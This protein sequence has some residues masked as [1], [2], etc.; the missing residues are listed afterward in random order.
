MLYHGCTSKTAKWKLNTKGPIVC[1]SI[2]TEFPEYANSQRQE[3]DWWGL[4]NRGEWGVT[5]N[6]YRV[7]LRGMSIV[8]LDS[9]DGC[10]ILWII[11]QTKQNTEFY[12]LKG[13]IS[14][15]ANSISVKLFKK[16]KR[17]C[18][19]MCMECYCLQIYS[20][21]HNTSLE[22]YNVRKLTLVSSARDLET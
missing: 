15:Y 16:K 6:E 9:S 8:K 20:H 5:T 11:K 22:R 14:Q 18:W 1:D 21:F 12:A 10:P 7:L 4:G 2:Y 17:S 3:V 19:T 13:W